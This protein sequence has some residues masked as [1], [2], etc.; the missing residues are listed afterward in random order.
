MDLN[1]VPVVPKTMWISG[2]LLGDVGREVVWTFWT[3]FG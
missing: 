1:E 3:W 2:G